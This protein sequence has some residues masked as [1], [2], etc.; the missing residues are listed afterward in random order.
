MENVLKLHKKSLH[1]ICKG[2]KLKIKHGINRSYDA[3]S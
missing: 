3:I 2:E 1:H